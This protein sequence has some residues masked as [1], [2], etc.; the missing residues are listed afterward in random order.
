MRHTVDLTPDHYI[1]VSDILRQH[2]PDREVL[3]FGSRAKGTAKKTSDLDLC[4][5]GEDRL[6]V[7]AIAELAEA[8]DEASLPFKVDIVEWAMLEKYF[9]DIV[10]ADGVSLIVH[11]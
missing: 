8:F 4:V 5:M 3:V 6:S 7:K 11:K 9:Q 10:N 2:I 1:I